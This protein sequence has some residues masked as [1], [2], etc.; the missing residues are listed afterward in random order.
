MYIRG[1]RISASKKVGRKER[2]SVEREIG[3]ERP[4]IVLRGSKAILLL[5]ARFETLDLVDLAVRSLM[6]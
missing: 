5:P 2:K 4:T 6:S 3:K 1:R